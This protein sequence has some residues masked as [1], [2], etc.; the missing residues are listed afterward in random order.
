MQTIYD[1]QVEKKDQSVKIL[2][3]IN[4]EKCKPI[5]YPRGINSN[6]TM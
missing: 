5:A 6:T 4:I 2:T 1:V 3:Q